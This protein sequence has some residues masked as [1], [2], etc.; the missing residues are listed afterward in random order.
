[1]SHLGQIRRWTVV[2]TLGAAL[3]LCG[4]AGPKTEPPPVPTSR[5]VVNVADFGA[6]GNG[7]T[8]DRPAIQAALDHAGPSGATVYFPAGIFR[9]AS[10]SLPL[11]R[12]LTTHANQHL[13]GAGRDV[14]RLVVG[15][16]FGNYVTVLGAARDSLG[17]GSW[18]MH[19]L[20]I[21][22]NARAGNSLEAA[23]LAR[24]PKMAVRIGDYRSSS[25]VSISRSSFRDS[26][27][28]NTLY[29]HAAELAVTENLFL[30]IGGG[31]G[32]TPHDH[33]TVYTSA[34]EKASTQQIA[35]NVFTGI[36]SSGG[37][38]TAIETHGGTQL[39]LDNVISDYLRGMNVTGVADVG[40][41]RVTVV[42]NTINRAAVG[43]QLWSQPTSASP[44]SGLKNVE[45]SQNQVGLDG[46]AW[47]I[48]GLMAPTAGVLFTESNTAPVDGLVISKNQFVYASS[49]PA[50]QVQRYTAGV[51]C[52]VTDA[53]GRATKITIADNTFTRAPAAIDSSCVGDGA[54]VTGN[55]VAG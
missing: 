31:R 47:R 30:N 7:A 20:A 15:A 36:R 29:L 2:L 5:P 22:Q 37:S 18:S 23:Q 43:I 9:L 34:T 52:R 42:R 12:I 46:G 16:T 24:Y 10:A 6:V 54:A 32:G 27:S 39:V 53:R 38:A 48:S 21:D 35:G 28:A 41:E 33:S 49:N 13:V 25:R 14:S 55:S 11:N 45:V 3:L 19:E 1:M 40:T 17:T 50:S 4:C 51:S 44:G 8:D 26:D